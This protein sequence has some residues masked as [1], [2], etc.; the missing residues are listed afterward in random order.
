MMGN[1]PQTSYAT[2]CWFNDMFMQLESKKP[3]L[4]LGVIAS[5]VANVKVFKYVVS[6][7]DYA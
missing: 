1:A 3:C 7:H 6:Y 4:L 5:P 2:M